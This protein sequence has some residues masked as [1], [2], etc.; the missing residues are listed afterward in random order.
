L[1][2]FNTLYGADI[3]SAQL[4]QLLLRPSTL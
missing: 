3:Q 2:L 1:T 4:S